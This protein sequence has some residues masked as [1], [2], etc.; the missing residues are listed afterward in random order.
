M[1]NEWIKI[2]ERLPEFDEN[3][4]SD[5]VLAYNLEK[6]NAYGNGVIHRC[7][8]GQ[9]IRCVDGINYNF[10]NGSDTTS[11]NNFTHWMHL[12]EPPNKRPCDWVKMRKRKPKLNKNGFSDWVLACDLYFGEKGLYISGCV[13]LNMF[14]LRVFWN[15]Y[16]DYD[17]DSFTH[18]MPLPEPPKE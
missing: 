2:S 8:G 1:M 11:K 9:F 16:N 13:R 17:I 14:G 7:R 12:P 3:G 10:W 6:E 15:G 18:W 5:W 4:R